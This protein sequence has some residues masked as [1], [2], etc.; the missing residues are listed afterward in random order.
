MKRAIFLLTSLSYFFASYAHA[1]KPENTVKAV[2]I[3]P[4]DIRGQSIVVILQNA[5]A[6]GFCMGVAG[7][8]MKPRTAVKQGECK[9]VNGEVVSVP[10]DQRWRLD[11]VGDGSY[12]LRNEK[13]HDRCLGVDHG[14]S[15][16]AD[17]LLGVCNRN[18]D[19]KWKF[20]AAPQQ[21]P[22]GH[23]VV[24][25]IQRNSTDLCVGVEQGETTRAQLK[26]N[27]CF[28][29]PDHLDQIWYAWRPRG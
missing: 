23:D 9:L 10:K 14:S 7:G 2:K 13:N 25:K 21:T 4:A 22:N 17:I 20:I 8:S 11:P 15:G 12:R 16:R 26:Q 18:P 5:K 29:N 3:S 19:Q 27:E 28:R 24:V 1:A 6:P